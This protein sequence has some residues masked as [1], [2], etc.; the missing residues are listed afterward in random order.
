MRLA[1]VSDIHANLEALEATVRDLA[2]QEVD[3][4]VCLGDI[5]GYNADPAE[6]VRILRS[7]DATCV[8]GNHDRAVA[9]RIA[10]TGFSERAVRA[11]LW[12]RERL[13]PDVLDFLADLPLQV[14][15]EPHLV[16]VHG[17]LL[18]QGGCERTYLDSDERRQRCFEA[19][20]SHPSR[21]RVCAY[22]HTHTLAVFELRQGAVRACDGE[23]IPLR[24]DAYYL[25][26]PGT[27][28]EPRDRRE[29]R[30]TYLV[31]DAARRTVSVRRVEYDPSMPA[32]KARRAGLGPRRR[33][34]LAASIRAAAQWS[35]GRLL[36][37]LLPGRLPAPRDEALQTPEA[38]TQ[39]H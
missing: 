36:P 38:R 30:A 31:L 6:C 20:A 14:S 16:A 12:T 28:G 15:I 2:R 10:T 11:V 9:G 1:I 32:L 18:P 4:V 23:E 34:S 3:R 24:E 5:V 19:L 29:H 8:A 39:R 21:A 25:V 22:G 7:L 17:M 33:A 35:A 13:A 26:N 27:I 37:R